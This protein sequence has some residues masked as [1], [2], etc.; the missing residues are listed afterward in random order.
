MHQVTPKHEHPLSE[1]HEFGIVAKALNLTPEAESETVSNAKVLGKRCE[2]SCARWA[3]LTFFNRNASDGADI[4]SCLEQLRDK[5]CMDTE[6]VKHIGQELV[7][8]MNEKITTGLKKT[9]KKKRA[10]KA[11]AAG[12][13]GGNGEAAETEKRVGGDGGNNEKDLDK[14]ESED[15]DEE[16]EEADEEVVVEPPAKKGK[17]K[18]RQY[19]EEVEVVALEPLDVKDK[20][21]LQVRERE[22]QAAVV[23]KLGGKSS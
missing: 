18:N 2:G 3:I 5:H 11:S 1:I 15:E 8:A 13:G 16:E 22:N 7:N 14:N 17:T 6:V 19:V 20:V 12:S 10:Q 9:F 4:T 23:R 21:A